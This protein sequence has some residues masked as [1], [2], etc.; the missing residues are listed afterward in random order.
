MQSF[1]R[2]LGFPARWFFRSA[3]VV[4]PASFRVSELPEAIFPQFL[5]G[6]RDL[7]FVPNRFVSDF[8][9]FGESG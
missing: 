2:W 4:L 9:E 8:V 6:R 1:R 7:H 5:R 3:D